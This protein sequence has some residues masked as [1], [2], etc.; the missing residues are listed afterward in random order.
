MNI[1]TTKKL[2]G[3]ILIISISFIFFKNES[4]AKQKAEE[5][6]DVNI[7]QIQGIE[8]KAYINL[9]PDDYKPDSTTEVSNAYSLAKK[10]NTIVKVIQAIASALSVGVLMIIAIKYMM[11]SVEEKAEYK[12]TML[13]YVIGC[14][15]VFGITN[16]LG[17]VV[18]IMS[19]LA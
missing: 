6:Y 14:F 5:N 13:P 8:K 18:D 17:I 12:K 10:G 16:I 3:I 11:G 7:I 4:L 1:K 9:R 19:K 15:L 2:I